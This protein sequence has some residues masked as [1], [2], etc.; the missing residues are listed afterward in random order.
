MSSLP[1]IYTIPE[2]KLIDK[3]LAERS[4]LEFYRQAWGLVEPA[5]E[6]INNWHIEAIAEHLEAVSRREITRLIINVPPGSMKSL[7]V[8]VFFPAWVW[9]NSPERRFIYASYSDTLSRR[10]SL[11][12]RRI[13][14]SDWYKGHWGNKVQPVKTDW[15]SGRFVNTAGGVR[16]C[17]TIGGGVTGEHADIQVVDDPI[18]PLEV[19]GSPAVASNTLERVAT[20]WTETM[21]SRL[22]DFNKSARIIIMQR[23]HEGDLA[24]LMEAAG[25]YDSLMLPMEY[26]PSRA[27]VTSIGFKDPR[28]T[29]GEL[30]WAERFT[31]EAVAKLKKDLGS[32][33][34]Q[35]QL[36][37]NPV[38][39]EGLIF[40]ESWIQYYTEPP[41]Y[42]KLIQSWDF[43]F[44]KVGS[45]YVVGQVWGI[46]DNNY[47]LVDEIR[48][49]FSFTESCK[50]VERLTQ[51]YPRAHIKLVEA[52]ANGNAIVDALTKKIQGFKL[53]EPEGGKEAR[54]QAVEPLWEGKNIYLP[55]NKDWV[56]DWITELL[57][58]PSRVDDDR[59]DAMSQALVYL[60]KRTL[61]KLKAAMR[62]VS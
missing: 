58:F 16:L 9:V 8:A 31:P 36:Q 44:K 23:L 60:H 41:K 10:D 18:K 25:G 2:A 57:G 7:A 14:E 47:Y 43:T 13:I 29:P 22:I 38:P 32:R 35:A 33:G 53:I 46:H 6:F 34:Y 19:T 40:K 54:A 59:V 51:K 30:L 45:S 15:N 56:G 48:G 4:L 28:R 17:T 1:G 21:S 5:R 3:A 62:R 12:C 24:G 20:W 26:E 50:A 52:K 39:S 37:Q 61:G 42:T 11:R 49:K 27:R 55:A